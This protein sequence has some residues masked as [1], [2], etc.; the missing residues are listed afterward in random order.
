MSGPATL[1]VANVQ[2][3]MSAVLTPAATVDEQNRPGYWGWTVGFHSAPPGNCDGS[4]RLE[5]ELEVVTSTFSTSASDV[6]IPLGTMSITRN[7]SFPI[8]SPVA[9]VWATKDVTVDLASGSATI[10]AFTSETMDGDFSGIGTDTTTN[11]TV[12]VTGTFSARRC[13]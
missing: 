5:G 1:G 7:L 10:S 13:E 11:A 2:S 4:G 3:A 6:M 8:T 9:I 12:T